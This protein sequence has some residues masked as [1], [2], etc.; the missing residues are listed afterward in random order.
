M[1][2]AGQA[3]VER[4][5]PCQILP[6]VFILEVGLR[7]GDLA[8][9]NPPYLIRVAICGVAAT[10]LHFA[11]A[12]AVAPAGVRPSA[13]QPEKELLITNTAVVDSERARYPGPWS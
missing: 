11:I 12:R 2:T 13:I 6:F 4:A 3:S 7:P 9:M 1:N 5:N 10:I 8:A